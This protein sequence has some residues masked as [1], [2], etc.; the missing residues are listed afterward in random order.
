MVLPGDA[1]WGPTPLTPGMASGF[2]PGEHSLIDPHE[3]D[4][5]VMRGWARAHRAHR[6]CTSCEPERLLSGFLIC[7]EC[8]G[9][10]HA[11]GR[12]A[13]QCS[14]GRDRGSELRASARY[15]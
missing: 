15:I 9:S 7:G 11:I 5:S 3:N 10:F 6:P 8:G 13:Q 14:W 4:D 12:G 2:G 1:A